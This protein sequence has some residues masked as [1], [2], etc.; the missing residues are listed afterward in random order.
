L[1]GAGASAENKA[2][3]GVE[4]LHSLDLGIRFQ[5]FAE[6]LDDRGPE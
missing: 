3:V 6:L 2:P 4:D 5:N 1:G